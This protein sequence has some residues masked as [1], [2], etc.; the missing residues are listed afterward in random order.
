MIP[1]IKILKNET[2]TA[3]LGE[4]DPRQAYAES[5]RHLRSALLLAQFG[6]N[7]PRTILFTSAMPGEGKSTVAMNLARILARSGLRVAV[8]DTDPHGG[9]MD[10]FLENPGQVGLSD[11]LRGEAPA[12]GI[13]QAADIPG[14]SY[15]GTG[16]YREGNEG[17]MLQPQLPAL[18]AELRK[19]H[20][21]V[22]LDGAPVLAADDAALLV[23]HA[24][25]VVLV[26]R[27]FY[28]RSRMVRRALEMLY[29]RQANHVAII[30]NQ[31]RPDD[32]SGQLYRQRN[33]AAK[34]GVVKKA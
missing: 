17:L 18:L 12:E 28:S 14:L 24:D 13:V 34:N 11:Y 8:M 32:L 23:P 9:G 33:G 6:E 10:K 15:I 16:N 25:T 29:Q 21:Y 19:N 20:E 1:R 3:L 22:I 27:P 30:Y 4:A 2:K 26:V 31:A 7:Q 5:Y